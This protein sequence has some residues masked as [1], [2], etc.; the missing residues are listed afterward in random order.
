MSSCM[1]LQNIIFVSFVS[2]SSYISISILIRVNYI[3][4]ISSALIKFAIQTL[5]RKVFTT[6]SKFS[7]IY[8][9]RYSEALSHNFSVFSMPE[10]GVSV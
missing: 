8:N 4:D 10:I 5:S 7:H 6:S 3:F 2:F 1:A 9:I